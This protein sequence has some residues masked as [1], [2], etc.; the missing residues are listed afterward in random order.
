MKDTFIH[1][2]RVFFYSVLK[3]ALQNQ[4]ICLIP[5]EFLRL[6]RLQKLKYFIEWKEIITIRR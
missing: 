4:G 5:S 3:K 2:E 6:Q 1:F